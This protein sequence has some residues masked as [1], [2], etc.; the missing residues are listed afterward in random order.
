MIKQMRV[1]KVKTLEQA[2]EYLEKKYLPWWEKTLTVLPASEENAHR[3]L[4][5]TTNLA[6]D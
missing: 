3:P 5:K 6:G 1:A 4:E 2:N